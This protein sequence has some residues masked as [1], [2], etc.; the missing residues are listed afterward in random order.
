[1]VRA[2]LVGKVLSEDER[3]RWFERGGKIVHRPSFHGWH[4]ANAIYVLHVG[5]RSK[6]GYFCAQCNVG[7]LFEDWTN[8]G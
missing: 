3:A 5:L 4:Y 8:D 7:A 2:L 6:V 1:M